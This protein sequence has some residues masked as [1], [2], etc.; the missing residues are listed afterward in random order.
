MHTL[1]TPPP[2]PYTPTIHPT[3]CTIY[4]HCAPQHL[5][6]THPL[7]TPTPAPYVPTVHPTTCSI[8]NHYAPH[9]LHH[10]HPLCIPPPAAYAPTVHPT[11]YTI[12]THCAPHHLHHMHPLCTPPPAPYA[13]TMYPTPCTIRTPEP[14]HHFS[15]SSTGAYSLRPLCCPLPCLDYYVPCFL[16][17]SAQAHFLLPLSPTE[18]SSHRYPGSHSLR[19]L[20][21]LSG[22]LLIKK[23]SE[24]FM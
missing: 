12:C 7:C 14:H 1:C 2:A 17:T 4:T 10:M 22:F 15:A 3:T 18:R 16:L 8:C 20:S 5:H 11:T 13:L 23:K 6:H 9:H 24:N 21:H 19:S